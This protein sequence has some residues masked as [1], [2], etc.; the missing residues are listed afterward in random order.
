MYSDRYPAGIQNEEVVAPVLQ[1]FK[2]SVQCAEQFHSGI[3]PGEEMD[4]WLRD[5]SLPIVITWV[6]KLRYHH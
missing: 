1:P 5:P 6:L 3:V 2:L 4:G